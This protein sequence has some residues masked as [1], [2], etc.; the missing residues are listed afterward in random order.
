MDTSVDVEADAESPTDQE[1]KFTITLEE[2][3]FD[4]GED[5]IHATLETNL[6]D[7]TVVNMRLN[8]DDELK[9]YPGESTVENGELNV[10][11]GDD[12]GQLVANGRYSVNARIKLTVF[13]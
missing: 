5:V 3:S 2:M 13:A 7:G 9:D 11:F 4:K 10:V 1:E 12:E 8:D 6:P